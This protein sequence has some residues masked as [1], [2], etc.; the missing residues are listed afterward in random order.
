MSAMRSCIIDTW[1]K[2]SK[3][4]APCLSKNSTRC[5]RASPLCFQLMAYRNRF[6]ADAEERDMYYL[7]ATCPLVTKVHVDAARHEKEGKD[8]ILIGHA[9]HPEVCRHDGPTP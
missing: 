7:D 1:S 3:P 6:L 2:T 9:G 4:K 5:P 8:L